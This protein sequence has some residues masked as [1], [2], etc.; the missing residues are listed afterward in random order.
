MQ[1]QSSIHMVDSFKCARCCWLTKGITVCWLT[2]RNWHYFFF[3][4]FFS[5]HVWN[6]NSGVFKHT[7]AIKIIIE[8]WL[9]IFIE[10][11]TEWVIIIFF[12]SHKIWLL[13]MNIKICI[14]FVEYS[15]CNTLKYEFPQKKWINIE[16]HCETRE[17][18]IKTLIIWVLIINDKMNHS[19]AFNNTGKNK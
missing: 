4:S 6:P 16:R 11:A 3:L 1:L 14:L 19:E 17:R 10:T 13:I 9:L 7:D 8:I 12:L 15:N 2:N 18:P 5:G